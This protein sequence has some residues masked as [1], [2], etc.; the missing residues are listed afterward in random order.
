MT[1][2]SSS[3]PVT[4]TSQQVAARFAVHQ[5][6]Q[7]HLSKLLSIDD[8]ARQACLSRH[9]FLRQRADA[10]AVSQQRLGVCAAEG[11]EAK[12]AKTGTA[13]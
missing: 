1:H 4:E 2:S 11:V 3:T 12:R 6:A 8:L 9:H 13:W 10:F 7:A 5:P